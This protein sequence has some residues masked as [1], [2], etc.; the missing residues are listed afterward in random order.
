MNRTAAQW[1]RD[2]ASKADRGADCRY[3][4]PEDID[5]IGR[6]A[7]ALDASFNTP[8]NANDDHVAR[9]KARFRDELRDPALPPETVADMTTLLNSHDSL[10]SKV[11]NVTRLCD[12]TTEVFGGEYS[13]PELGVYVSA[14]RKA[15]T[16]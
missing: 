16:D 9:I 13:E 2:L 14:L 8:Q 4:W 5:E 15:L 7:A 3:L 1:L 10:Q 6:I 12:T 11:Q